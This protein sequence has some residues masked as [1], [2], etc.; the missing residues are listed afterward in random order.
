MHRL[1]PHWWLLTITTS[2]NALFSTPCIMQWIDT[3]ND[4]LSDPVSQKKAKE[5][6]IRIHNYSQIAFGP[7]DWGVDKGCD[8]SKCKLRSSSL[9]FPKDESH[10]RCSESGESLS[11]SKIENSSYQYL[12]R[13]YFYHN[14]VNAIFL[15]LL[16]DQI[17]KIT[18]FF[19]LSSHSNSYKICSPASAKNLYSSIYKY[20]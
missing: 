2:M 8:N 14:I 19:S 6:K 17:S 16:K 4:V 13:Y 3:C 7:L 12:M 10:R 20:R 11:R 5:V 15:F 1:S 18:H 9:S